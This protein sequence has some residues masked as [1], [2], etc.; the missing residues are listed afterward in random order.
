MF[1]P[2]HPVVASVGNEPA[3]VEL[4]NTIAFMVD[5]A[6]DCKKVG[7]IN[8][9]T[10]RCIMFLRVLFML[11][12]SHALCDY[13]LQGQ[14]IAENKSPR[15]CNSWFWQMFAHGLIHAGGVYVVTHM[16]S[17][18]LMQLV[19]HIIIDLLKCEE[20]FGYNVDQIAHY[21]TMVML[22]LCYAGIKA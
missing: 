21:I 22:A 9:S 12:V 10:G 8:C 7:A 1:Y 14:Y 5:F 19:A 17:L 4:A 20:V 13:P 2:D 16:V 3:E 11:F 6:R 15:K 18:A